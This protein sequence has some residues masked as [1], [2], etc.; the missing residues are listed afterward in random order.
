MNAE[1]KPSAIASGDAG[2]VLQHTHVA[3]RQLGTGSVAFVSA[4]SRP[5]LIAR[6][7]ADSREPSFVAS[8]GRCW[9]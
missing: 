9:V 3:I 6:H 8:G 2:D 5:T 7:R 4:Q 1:T